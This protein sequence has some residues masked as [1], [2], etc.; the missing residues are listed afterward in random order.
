MAEKQKTKVRPILNLSAPKQA[1]F[2]DFVNENHIRKLEMS[3]A[4]KFDD[5][6]KSCGKSPLMAKYNIRDAYKIIPGH[7]SQWNCFGFK[8]LGKYFFDVT[9]VFGSKSAPAKFYSIPETIV[10]IVCTETEVPKNSVFRQ[11]DDVPVVAPSWS[12]NAKK[13]ADK[14]VEICNLVGIPL[15][16]NC[17][18]REKSFRIGTSG[19]VLGI[20]FNSENLTWQ[21]PTTKQT[22]SQS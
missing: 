8:W 5:A 10:N 21:I 18:N 11:L 4:A 22:E 15:A 2:N 1:S 16:E 13:F 6:V 7:P 3:S 12:D 17:P 20:F 14:Y 19:T 9:T